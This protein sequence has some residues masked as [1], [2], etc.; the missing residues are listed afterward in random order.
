MGRFFVLRVV[1][2]LWIFV[3]ERLLGWR[4]E[5][6]P[7]E[8]PKAILVAG[9]HT[10]NLDMAVVFY[11]ACRH[12]RLPRWVAKESLFKIPILGA[13]MPAFGGIPIDRSA[14]LKALKGMLKAIRDTDQILLLIAPEGTR[15]YT[16]GWKRGFYYV[17]EKAKIPL[18]PGYLDYANK[19]VG[20]GPLLHPTGD[21]AADLT[22]LAEVYA[23]RTARHPENAAPVRPMPE[24]G[25]QTAVT[26]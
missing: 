23:G 11:W 5:G 6:P 17:A 3:F 7:P 15:T 2:P 12:R 18:M 24:E 10:A 16:P 25:E 19:V 21:F 26:A 4:I 13:L 1:S 22:V 8:A 14:P 20:I 9:P